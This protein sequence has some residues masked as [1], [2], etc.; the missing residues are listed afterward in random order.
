MSSNIS[1][2]SQT[3]PAEDIIRTSGQSSKLIH[4]AFWEQNS[5]IQTASGLKKWL[6]HLLH[7]WERFWSDLGHWNSILGCFWEIRIRKRDRLTLCYYNEI[8]WG[9]HG[10]FSLRLWWWQQPLRAWTHQARV[11][12]VAQPVSAL[13]QC[14]GPGVSYQSTCAFVH[15]VAQILLITISL[16]PCKWVCE[17]LS[18]DITLI[19]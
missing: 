1:F 6:R 15:Q 5:R 18:V 13:A 19:M 9:S 14:Y 8:C 7:S 2:D 17:L 12:S 16:T 4:V 11:G 3:F 10:V